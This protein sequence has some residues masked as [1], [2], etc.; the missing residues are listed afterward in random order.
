MT[1]VHLADVAIGV[2]KVHETGSWAHNNVKLL[3]SGF[4]LSCGHRSVDCRVQLLLQ[5]FPC[6]TLF[7]EKVWGRKCLEE[8]ILLVTFLYST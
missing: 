2:I 5:L 4:S 7:V 1:L 8:K 3:H 6:D